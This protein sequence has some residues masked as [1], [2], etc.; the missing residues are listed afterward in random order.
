MTEKQPLNRQ[1]MANRIAMEF[2]DGWVV[3]L[4]SASLRSAPTSCTPISR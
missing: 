2:H 3:N 4:A 1:T